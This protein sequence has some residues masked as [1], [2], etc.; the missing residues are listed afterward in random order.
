MRE[1]NIKDQETHEIFKVCQ[2]CGRVD[3]EGFLHHGTYYCTMDC[4][5]MNDSKEGYNIAYEND[6]SYFTEWHED[7]DLDQVNLYVTAI[8]QLMEYFNTTED[9]LWLPKQILRFAKKRKYQ[10]LIDLLERD[11]GEEIID[12]LYSIGR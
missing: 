12:I 4:L 9:T 6:Y 2:E 3:T 8:N 5:L 7:Y 10:T 1:L 11:D